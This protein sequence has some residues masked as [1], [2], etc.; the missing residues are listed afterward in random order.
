[1]TQRPREASLRQRLEVAVDAVW[2][3]GR[4]TLR[5]FQGPIPVELKA[6][7]T[8]VTLADR[9][10]EEV[11]FSSL[12]GAFP[13]DG[14]LGEERGEVEG[15]SGFRWVVD[16]IDGT[17][18]FLQGVPLY[19]VLAALED[20][21]GDVIVGVAGFP[22]LGEIVAAARG[23]GCWWNG[24]RARVSGTETLAQACVAYTSIKTFEGSDR[25]GALLRLH[26]AC[27][28]ARGWGDCYGHALVATGRADLMV[29]PVLADW[30]CAALVPILEEAGGT[31]TD[32]SGRKTW[33]GKSGISTNGRLLPAV[34]ALLED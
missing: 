1:M 34:Q 5:H 3:A 23:E 6:D 12:R 20:P 21:G 10:S 27:R 7:S 17:K 15:A 24:R 9:E 18:S 28:I 25:L 29:D 16:P 4:S 11:L 32:W 2:K 31:F 22:A 14:F 30:D 13:A 33:K 8:P 26:A 19:G